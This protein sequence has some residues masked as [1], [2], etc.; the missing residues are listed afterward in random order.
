M[1]EIWSMSEVL[2]QNLTVLF[3]DQLAICDKELRPFSKRERRMD[4]DDEIKPKSSM[5]RPCRRHR[6]L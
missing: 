2:Q 6:E 3:R 5:V 4:D 1:N